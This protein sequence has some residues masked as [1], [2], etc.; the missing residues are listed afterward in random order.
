MNL[1]EN[2]CTDPHRSW[3]DKH[4]SPHHCRTNTDTSVLHIGIVSPYISQARRVSFC[5]YTPFGGCGESLD[6]YSIAHGE[7]FAIYLNHR[8]NRTIK[9][10]C[11]EPPIM[12]ITELCQKCRSIHTCEIKSR[13]LFTWLQKAA[14]HQLVECKDCGHHWKEFLPMQPLLN[15]V[16]LLLAV[17]IIFLMT[18][19][20]KE[21]AHYL[22]G[23]FS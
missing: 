14:G 19:Y 4:G 3:P 15:L 16:Y 23:V 12:D 7:C 18:S 21:L 13:S 10:D 1:C 2:F 11:M 5:R 17:E 6:G 20:Y 9:N 8:K 22:S